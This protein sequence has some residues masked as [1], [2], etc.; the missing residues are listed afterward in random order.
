MTCSCW[1]KTFKHGGFDSLSSQSR[2]N[3]RSNVT[4]VD[5]FKRE[6]VLVFLSLR[7]SVHKLASD[8]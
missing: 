6:F 2:C 5:I 7:C 4:F 3:E 1:H 8:G